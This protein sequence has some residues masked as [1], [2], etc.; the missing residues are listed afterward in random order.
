M[1]SESLIGLGA[2]A[3][4]FALS[5]YL[6]KRRGGVAPSPACAVVAVSPA[7]ASGSSAL[8]AFASVAEGC[9][10]VLDARDRVVFANTVACE[11]LDFPAVYAGEPVAVLVRS[12]DFLECLQ[13]VRATGLVPER[14]VEVVLRR[15]PRADELAF[16]LKLGM[17]PG[18]GGYGEGALVVV[19]T[20]VSHL[21]RLESVRR[22]FVANVSHD[23]RTPVTIIKGYTMTLSEDYALMDD[24]DRLRFLEKIRRN[25]ER[26]H[27]LLESLLE[28][29]AAEGAPTAPLRTGAMHQAVLEAVDMLSDRLTESGLRP[30][31]DL[32]ADDGAVAVDPVAMGRVVRNL[33]EN[34]LRYAVGATRVRV[35]SRTDPG[36]GVTELSVEDDGPGVA[37]ADYAKIF[38]RFYRAEKSR[39]LAHGGSGLGLAIVRSLVRAQGGEVLAESA[40]PHGFVV[41]ITL[42][43]A[44]APLPA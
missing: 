37:A 22:E 11:L 34:S 2:F 38:Q 27:G 35:A 31:L 32:R 40:Q 30:E 41:R 1:L 10:V 25:T 33:L 14:S 20:D 21:R 29:A 9:V 44:T 3:S 42:P 6:A 39:S 19:L 5:R 12:A 23:L 15:G 13:R 36:T 28:L 7:S 8:E 26:L 4:G 43:R 17:L 18:A 24:V 16:S